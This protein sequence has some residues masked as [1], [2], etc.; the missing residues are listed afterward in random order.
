MSKKLQF[1]FLFLFLISGKLA[2]AQ[3]YFY[4]DK[5]FE[6]NITFEIGGSV[7]LMNCLTDI[8]GRSGKGKKFIK[9]LNTKNTQL[10]TGIFVN[11]L[12]KNVLGLRLEGTFGKVSAY[13]S[14][15]IGE[16]GDAK[17]RYNRNLNFRSNI[18]ELSAMIE[19]HP[20]FLK[21]Y[22]VTDG[23]SM[24]ILSPYIVGGVSYFSFKPQGYLNNTWID[25]QP[26]RNEGQGFPEY[27]D[28]KNYSLSQVNI[29]LGFG[30]KYELGALFNARL[31]FVHRVLFTDYLDDV[32]TKYIDP[33]LFAGRLTA[34]KAAQ[35]LAWNSRNLSTVPA[36]YADGAIRGLK[37]KDTYFSLNLKLGLVLGRNKVK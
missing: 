1:G 4:N 17:N 9:D 2:T 22:D 15:L 34:N 25:L 6:S 3:Y 33:S 12:Y 37:D 13:D 11:A 31:E 20:L 18:T 7:G 21:N 14:I 28:R 36:D 30:V 5:Y 8:G 35:A 23:S 29:P 10:A 27:I 19:F 24:P 16:T 32:S 26:L